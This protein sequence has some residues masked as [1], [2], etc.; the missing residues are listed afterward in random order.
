MK[1]ILSLVALGLA[2][3]VAGPAFAADEPT[4]KADCE[5]IQGMEWDESAGKC[6]K[7]SPGG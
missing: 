2:L 7:E 5:K 3:A 4:T 1:S 6:V